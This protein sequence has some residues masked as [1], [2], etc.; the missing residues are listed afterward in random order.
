MHRHIA[1]SDRRRSEIEMVKLNS[2]M[3]EESTS[4]QSKC[5]AGTKGPAL[6]H[7]NESRFMTFEEPD[8]VL[9]ALP[10]VLVVQ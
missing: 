10:D 4:L 1:Y 7:S 6:K 8:E 5:Q 3:R 9:V 2:V